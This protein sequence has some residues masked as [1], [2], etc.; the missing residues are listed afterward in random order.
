VLAT[1]AH[2]F[3]GTTLGMGRFDEID[4]QRHTIPADIWQLRLKTRGQSDLVVQSNVWTAGGSTGWHTHPGPTLIIITAGAVTVYESDDSDC[5]PH[6]YGPGTAL[7]TTFVDPGDDHVHIIRNETATEAR[8]VAVRL[9]PA[10][11]M[12]RID[13]AHPSNCPASI[14]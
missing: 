5:A 7:G 14:E 12:G 8:G 11:A 2:G 13:A 1:T 3:T 4:I 6:I 9:I 10:A